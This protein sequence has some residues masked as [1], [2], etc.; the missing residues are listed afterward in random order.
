MGMIEKIDA[1]N[2]VIDSVDD[3]IRDYGTDHLG[4]YAAAL[5]KA[6]IRLRALPE[7]LDE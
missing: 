2:A 1:I 5:E 3:I 6:L 7:V 4:E